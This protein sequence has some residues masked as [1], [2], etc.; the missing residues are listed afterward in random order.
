MNVTGDDAEA[1]KSV[2]KAKKT[3]INKTLIRELQEEFLDTPVEVQNS[4]DSFS[5]KQTRDRQN[6]ER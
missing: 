2:E 4:G 1:K 5:A 6:K 3:V